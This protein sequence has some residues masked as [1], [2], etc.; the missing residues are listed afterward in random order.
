MI[1]IRDTFFTFI[2]EP[3]A[4]QPRRLKLYYYLCAP[5]IGKKTHQSPCDGYNFQI[6]QCKSMDFCMVFK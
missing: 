4:L 5:K 6:V 2:L 1:L 3:S